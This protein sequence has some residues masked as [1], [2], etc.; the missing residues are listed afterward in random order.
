MRTNKAATTGHH[1]NCHRLASRNFKLPLLPYCNDT[2]TY[3]PQEELVGG[4]TI[5][6]ILYLDLSIQAAIIHL[7]FGSLQSSSGLPGNQDGPSPAPRTAPC[8]L[9]G[10]APCGVCQAD[11]LP[12]RWCALTAPF[13]PYR[14]AGNSSSSEE[15]SPKPRRYIFCGTFRPLRALELRG[16]LPCGVRTFLGF[17]RDRP[18]ACQ[19][20][21]FMHW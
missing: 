11:P 4:P 17:R 2:L 18:S 10:L 12:D 8:S 13:H 14:E 3:R 1:V 5:S 20:Y 15:L 16:T 6:R 7:G 9:F 21:D 19:S